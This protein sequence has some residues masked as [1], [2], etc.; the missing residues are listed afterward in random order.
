MIIDP[1]LGTINFIHSD[2]SKHIRVRILSDGLRV[3][4]PMRESE[5]NAMTFID[6]IRARLIAKQESL[7]EKL[8]N[9]AIIIDETSKLQTLTFSVE[10]KAVARKDIFYTLENS[11]LTI[12]FPAGADTRG[13]QMQSYF[14]NG[15]TYFLRKD[16]KKILPN[17][18]KE[19]ATE[20]GFQFAD[21]KIQSSKT[22]WGSCSRGRSLNLSLYLLLLPMHLIDYVILHE[23]CHT[24]E[25]NHGP[26]F[27]KWMDKVTDGKSKALR[28]ELKKY[29]M[30]E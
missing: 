26:N 11:I 25:M 7:E 5:K 10:P 21:V 3:S 13:K 18:T 20:F 16:A 17:K 24:K 28:A 15:I 8:Q 2:R 29:N 22:R 27:W 23:L 19:L 12:E 4:M 14:W 6:S 9:N 1:E 30:P